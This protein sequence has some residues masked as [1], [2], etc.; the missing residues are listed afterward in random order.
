MS[1][2]AKTELTGDRFYLEEVLPKVRGSGLDDWLAEAR[3]ATPSTPQ[4]L[5]TLV[6]VHCR[7]MNLFKEISGLEK[8]SLAS[9]YLHSHVPRLFYIYDARATTALNGL[10]NK[11]PRETRVAESG[12]REYRR[13]VERCEDLHSF[14]LARFEQGVNRANWTIFCCEFRKKRPDRASLRDPAS[15]APA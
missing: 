14:C 6:T 1:G 5:A 4:G 2:E 11:L 3:A 13:F 10:R 8:R 9:K 7:T 15:S 12:D